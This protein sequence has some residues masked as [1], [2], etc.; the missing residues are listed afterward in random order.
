MDWE[1]FSVALPR[2]S[3]KLEE[4]GVEKDSIPA[5]IQYA[6]DNKTPIIY[7][8]DGMIVPKEEAMDW[9]ADMSTNEIILLPNAHKIIVPLGRLE[10][11]SSEHA[12]PMMQ[13]LLRDV[14][15]EEKTRIQ[16]RSQIPPYQYDDTELIIID[17]TVWQS[18]MD[19]LDAQHI[20]QKAMQKQHKQQMQDQHTHNLAQQGKHPDT[21]K[22]THQSIKDTKT[23]K[24]S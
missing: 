10:S 23:N 12:R 22:K 11:T 17:E 5:Y 24:R 2:D 19:F 15:G 7:I 6:R 1:R 8:L 21:Y 20:H 13:Y 3:K 14:E 18:T 16:E 4:A 9:M